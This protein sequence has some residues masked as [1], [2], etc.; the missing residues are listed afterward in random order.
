MILMVSNTK[1]DNE[2]SQK[3]VLITG[4]CGFL[5]HHLVEHIMKTT[6]WDIVV[7][8]RLNYAS[9]GYDRLRGVEAYNHKKVKLLAVDLSKKFPEGVKREIGEV[10][11]I[12]HL[13]AETHVQRSIEDPEPFVM[14]NVVGTFWLLEFARELK[15]LKKFI[16]FSTDEVFGD[17]P[18]GVKYKENDRYNSRNPY[19]ATKA[20]GEELAMAYANTY[21]LPIIATHCM[22]IF[23]ER[24]HP[25]KFVPICINKI[26]KGETVKIHIDPKTKKPG[27]RHWIHAR[28]VSASILF[29]TDKSKDGEKYNIVPKTELNNLEVAQLVAKVMGKELK[30]ELEDFH[31][32]RPGHDPRYSLDGTKMEEMGWMLPVPFSNSFEKMVKWCIDD[33]N[34]SWLEV[35]K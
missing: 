32:T 33:K 25:E 16:Y 9:K 6:D 4:A 21:K 5:G 28:N 22:N 11:Y 34:K 14:A 12:Y 27:S 20:G 15:N 35:D 19:A 1:Q 2:E 8:D 17:A 23:G 13:A 31:S 24:Q 30:Y 7:L 26:L 10:D 3:R 29:L 18:I